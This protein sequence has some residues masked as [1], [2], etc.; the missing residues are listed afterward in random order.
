MYMYAIY[1]LKSTVE[2]GMCFKHANSLTRRRK[3]GYSELDSQIM[4]STLTLHDIGY[5]NCQRM[6]YARGYTLGIQFMQTHSFRQS[7]SGWSK[8]TYL[9]K[10]S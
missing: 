5:G 2:R 1:R 4:T 10:R 7:G 8:N 3:L 6:K 9:V